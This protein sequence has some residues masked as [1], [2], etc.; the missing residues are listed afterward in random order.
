MFFVLLLNQTETE[1]RTIFLFSKTNEQTCFR[2]KDKFQN[3]GS[4]LGIL[5]HINKGNLLKSTVDKHES[6]KLKFDLRHGEIDK[7]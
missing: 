2:L 7:A 4:H 3:K 5:H 1:Q 6:S